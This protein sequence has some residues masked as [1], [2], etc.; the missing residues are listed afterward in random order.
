[1]LGIIN[2]VWAPEAFCVSFKLETDEDILI[3]KAT[4]AIDK[5]NISLVVA[6][7]LHTRNSLVRLVSKKSRSSSVEVHDV[8]KGGDADIEE[9]LVKNVAIAH[10]E[11]IGTCNVRL[12]QTS[13]GMPSSRANN[14]TLRAMVPQGFPFPLFAFFAVNGAILISSKFA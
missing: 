1:M 8:H 6:N 12:S 10:F 2:N 4:G 13:D 14:S 11:H 7:E 5:Y 3:K 9:A